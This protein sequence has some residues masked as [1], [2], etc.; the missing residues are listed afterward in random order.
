MPKLPAPPLPAMLRPRPKRPGEG[1]GEAA[2]L[3]AAAEAG[4]SAVDWIDERTSLSGA[5][6]WMMFRKVPKGTNWFYTLGT[7]T[8]FAFLNQ[9]V[10]G[11][12]LAMYY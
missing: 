10:T 1:N 12:F 8:M 7:A 11:V 2:P 4:I 6:R 9:A 3:D 5:A